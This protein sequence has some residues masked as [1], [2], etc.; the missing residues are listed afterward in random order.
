MSANNSLARQGEK[1]FNDA[2][3]C[4]Q[5]W[6]SCASCHPD[7][8]A[9]G[10][11]WDLLNDGM[12]NPKNTKSLL[13]AHQTPPAMIT[14]IRDRAETAVRTGIRYIQFAHR[15]EDDTLAI[16]EYLKSLQPIPSPHLEDGQLSKAAKRGE[17]I[18]TKAGCS[19]CHTGPLRTDMKMYDVG[20]GIGRETGQKFDTPTLIEIWRTAPYL[21]D[22]RA[23]T[24][25]ELLTK[26]NRDNKHGITSNLSDSEIE[27]LTAFIL[28]Q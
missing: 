23:R 19:N 26:D 5:Q 4:F 6:Q 27:D 3:L 9:D 25:Q 15:P 17:Q 12:G 14:G 20:T 24:I 7:G 2:S 18:F 8:R 10:L 22:G 28:S 16:D 21:Y 13:L 11:N 1:L